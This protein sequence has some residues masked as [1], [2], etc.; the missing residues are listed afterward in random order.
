[1]KISYKVLQNYVS[2]LGTPE[3]VAQ[4]LVMHTAEVEEIE[5][6]G[7]NLE[8]VFIGEVKTCEKHPDSEKLNCTTVEV[9]GT[10]YPI[11][12]GA[13]NVAAGQKV[14]VATVGTK[15]Y[16]GEGNAFEIKKSKIRGEA[17]LGM[18]CAEDELGLGES[19]DGIM[20]LETD[21][22]PG[23]ACSEIF[24]IETDTVIEIGDPHKHCD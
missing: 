18:I 23:T 8:K 12:C 21:L 15:L 10:T 4:D 24:D 7:G 22:V 2:D 6:E 1:M 20:V 11:V 9:N 19:H 16:D 3:E 17:S 14:A 5:Y 13:P